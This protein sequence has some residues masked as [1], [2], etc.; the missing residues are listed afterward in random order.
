MVSPEHQANLLDPEVTHIG[1]GI[2]A[3]AGNDVY[4]I[5]VFAAPAEGVNAPGSGADSRNQE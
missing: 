1:Y 5:Q 2:A 4:A 3:G